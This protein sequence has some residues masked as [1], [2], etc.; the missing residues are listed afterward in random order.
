ML[1]VLVLVLVEAPNSWVAN[2][3]FAAFALG[4]LAAAALRLVAYRRGL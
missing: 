4:G 3:P 2:A 1:G